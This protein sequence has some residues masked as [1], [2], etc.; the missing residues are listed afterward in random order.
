MSVL[1]MLL[2]PMPMITMRMLCTCVGDESDGDDH[3]Y[4]AGV[5]V[6]GNAGDDRAID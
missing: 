4:D 3:T 5:A 2:T 6:G 1:L